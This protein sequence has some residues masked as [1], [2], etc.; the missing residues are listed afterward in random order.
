[1][2]VDLHGLYRPVIPVVHWHIPGQ[3]ASAQLLGGVSGMDNPLP[4]GLHHVAQTVH[5]HC[6]RAGDRL[7]RHRGYPFHA[8]IRSCSSLETSPVHDVATCPTWA[9]VAMAMVFSGLC[10][11][12]LH[13]VHG[14]M[15]VQLAR[16]QLLGGVCGMG[17]SLPLHVHHVARYVPL[18]DV[19][20]GAHLS[21]LQGYPV[22]ARVGLSGYI[23]YS[24]NTKT[25]VHTFRHGPTSL[26]D[27]SIVCHPCPPFCQKPRL[28]HF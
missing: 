14:Q 13:V 28:E 25:W 9:T 22:N 10:R 7:S 16:A 15:P 26:E 23:F 6:V 4:L 20:D 2:A 5:L 27:R 18:H 19:R 21:W 24:T 3:L 12:V 11:P 17:H 1:M 8:H